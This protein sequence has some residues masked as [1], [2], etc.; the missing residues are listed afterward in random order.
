MMLLCSGGCFAESFA[1][2]YPQGF[3]TC[4]LPVRPS[5]RLSDGHEG[6]ERYNRHVCVCGNFHFVF[7]VIHVTLFET[8]IIASIKHAGI[9]N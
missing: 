6:Y 7:I 5:F 3:F 9:I 8:C 2:E 1:S 4:D